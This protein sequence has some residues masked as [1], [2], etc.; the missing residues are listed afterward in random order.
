MNRQPAYREVLIHETH[1]LQKLDA[2]S[3]TAISLAE[4]IVGRLVSCHAWHAYRHDESVTAGRKVKA[5]YR[6]SLPGRL[7]FRAPMW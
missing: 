6:C 1:H 4:Q 7:M 5:N 2:P 3:G